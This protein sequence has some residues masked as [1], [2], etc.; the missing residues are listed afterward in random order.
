MGSDAAYWDWRDQILKAEDR[1]RGG[2]PCRVCEQPI[3]A[4]AHWKHRDRH[5]CSP[6]CNLTLNRRLNRRIERGEIERPPVFTPD[7]QPPREPRVFRTLAANAPFPYEI[8]GYSPKPGDLVERHGSVTV[9]QRAV[10]LPQHVIPWQVLPGENGHW[11]L[12]RV[13][14]SIHVATGSAFYYVTDT[15]WT[16]TSLILGSFLG[17]KHLGAFDSFEAEGERWQWYT[18]IIRDVDT[19]GNEFTW[20]A[21]VCGKQSIPRLW[22]PAYVAR[23]Q[24]LKRESSAAGSYAARMRKLGLEG[25]IERLD[26]QEIYKRDGWVCRICLS[27]VDRGRPWPDMWSPTLDHKIPLTA[28]GEHTRENVQLSHWICN[29][30]KGDR[31]LIE[32]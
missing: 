15:S 28:G 9:V 8:Q 30:H 19:E 7:P 18:E 23:S 3:P 6:R 5:V 2:E 4:K 12:D 20:N 26:P 24:R 17:L 14:V 16:P 27:P 22:T 29:L 21:Y 13:A 1:A 11:D 10:D 32:P 25:K 31:F